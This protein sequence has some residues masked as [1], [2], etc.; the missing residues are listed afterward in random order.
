MSTAPTPPS[1]GFNAPS[2]PGSGEKEAAEFAKL[3]VDTALAQVNLELTRKNLELAQL[4]LEKGRLAFDRDYQTDYYHRTYYFNAVV[5][6][7]SVQYCLG[8]LREWSRVSKDPITIVFNSPGG[9]VSHG[10]ALYDVIREIMA[11]GV[12]VTT[13]VYGRAASMGGIL[14]Q[15][16]STRQMSPNSY[17]MIHEP[18]SGMI[19][20]AFELED[21]VEFVKRLWDQLAEIL[22]ERSTLTARQIKTKSARK[23]WWLSAEESLKYGFIDEVV[24]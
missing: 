5:E 16:G 24:L 6:E 3:Q 4:N 9:V 8:N 13:K 10:L 23:D 12:P 14:L 19:G 11:E 15:A 22:A 20:K 1:G 17:L 2:S 18:S 7:K 21:N